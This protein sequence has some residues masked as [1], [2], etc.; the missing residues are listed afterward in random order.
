MEERKGG[1]ERGG[2]EEEDSTFTSISPSLDFSL[3]LA[4]QQVRLSVFVPWKDVGSSKWLEFAH[5][6]SEAGMQLDT[7][8]S[9]ILTYDDSDMLKCC[10][11]EGFA[12]TRLTG[13][14]SITITCNV[15]GEKN[16]I[17]RRVVQQG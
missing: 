9:L 8:W 15:T 6:A 2:R 12:V 13:A 4:H 17:R 1:Y 7:Y 14:I 16:Y 10:K 5:N 11:F 3:V